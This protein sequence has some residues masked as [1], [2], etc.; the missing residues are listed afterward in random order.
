[1]RTLPG[2]KFAASPIYHIQVLKENMFAGFCYVSNSSN[3]SCQSQDISKTTFKG[4]F[5]TLIIEF[6]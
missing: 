3:L 6:I 4:L 2:N 1:M 5:Y